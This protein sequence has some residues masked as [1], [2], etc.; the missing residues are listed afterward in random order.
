MHPGFFV[1]VDVLYLRHGDEHGSLLILLADVG[2]PAEDEHTHDH[3]QHQQP[4][5][6]V[7]AQK[8]TRQDFLY[9]KGLG[10]EMNGIFCVVL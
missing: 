8:F 7:A 6:L 10:H 5:L 9:L 2:Q 3:H 1:V 4:E